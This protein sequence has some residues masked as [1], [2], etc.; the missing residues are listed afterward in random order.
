MAG[1]RPTGD[2][3]FREVDE[4]G[5]RWE[6]PPSVDHHPLWVATPFH[7]DCGRAQIFGAFCRNPYPAQSLTKDDVLDDIT[8]CWLTDTGTSAGRLYWEN[9][10]RSPV[11]ASAFKT[12]QIKLSVAI[13]IFLEDSDQPPESWARRAFPSLSYY[14]RVPSGDSASGHR[15]VEF[16]R[17]TLARVHAMFADAGRAIGAR[18]ALCLPKEHPPAI[19]RSVRLLPAQQ[20]YRPLDPRFVSEQLARASRPAHI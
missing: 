18:P 15:R 6:S 5:N 8:L 17:A 1:G 19:V 7:Q 9:K 3:H 4:A 16:D 2:V 11:I 13:S 20:G 14:N 12:D 10:G